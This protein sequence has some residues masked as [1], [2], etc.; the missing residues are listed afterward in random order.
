[1]LAKFSSEKEPAPVSGRG[2]WRE[3]LIYPEYDVEE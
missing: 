2:P 3:D 1:M